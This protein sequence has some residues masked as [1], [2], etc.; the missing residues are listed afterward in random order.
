[1]SKATSH[2]SP[3]RPRILRC[4][5]YTRK[6]S[7]EGLEQDFNSLDAQREACEAYI[8][9]QKHEGWQCLP[10]S[11]DDG[12]ISGGTMDRPALQSLLADIKA[13]KIDVVVVYKVDRLTRSLADFAKM[14]EIFD[15]RKVSFVSITQQLNTTTSMGRLTLNV[16][17]SFA[18]FE[19]E[20]TGERIRDKI[21]ASKKKGM[22]MG[23]NPPL[24]Y[25]VK[26]RCLV[27]NQ[28]EAKTVRHIFRCYAELGTVR[29]LKEALDEQGIVSK[30]RATQAGRRWGG[31]SITRGALYEMLR[32]R[33]Y[34]GQIR[35]KGQAYPGN[36]KP[37][38]D[39][40]LWDTVQKKLDDH[41]VEHEKGRS[42]AISLLTGLLYDGQ[43]Q[44][45]TPTHAV[46]KDGRRYRYYVSQS[47]TT[48]IRSDYPEGL[49]VPAAEIEK[50]VVTKLRRFLIDEAAIFD[51]IKTSVCKLVEQRLLLK[52]AAKL[53]NDWLEL[54]A[55]RVRLLLH[56][57][58]SRIELHRDRVIIHLLPS[59]LLAVLRGDVN[60]SKDI[61]DE[62]PI[63]LTISANLCHT[64][65]GVRMIVNGSGNSYSEAKPDLSLIKILVKAHQF[66]DK[67]I[68]SGGICIDEV[69]G[70]DGMKGSYFTRLLRL[71]W[72]A[73]D[74]T[75]AI[76]EGKHPPNLTAL[77][78]QTDSR[79]PLL[80]SEQ[81]RLLGFPPRDP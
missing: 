19:R 41:G 34:I 1:M 57:L 3:Q 50:Q 67:L 32:N 4:A 61:K 23:G 38:I 48:G 25:D 79:L 26:D 9:S 78:L 11:Y 10:K 70:R 17:L 62:A 18:Q 14:V 63:V 30:Q 31:N 13:G 16:L 44:R 66:K 73:P 33:I 60:T 52:S 29:L 64:K 24:G 55:P 80:W 77:R 65:G 49:R 27:V 8:K 35:H 42:K 45:M 15:S 20:V 53:R 69:A 59:R 81:R 37:V 36:H 71:T 43:G 56:T 28:T 75:A 68:H 58:L 76:L 47:L 54:P 6:S 5:I 51:A 2:S 72:L 74:I 12:G 40:A 7:E 39:E 46:T 21:A 22:W